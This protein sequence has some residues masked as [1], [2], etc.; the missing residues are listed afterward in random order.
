MSNIIKYFIYDGVNILNIVLKI[1]LCARL[2]NLMINKSSLVQMTDQGFRVL[3]REKSGI[4]KWRG[5][6][7]SLIIFVLNY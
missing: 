4:E 7:L 1:L 6:V 2:D 3:Y 5:I